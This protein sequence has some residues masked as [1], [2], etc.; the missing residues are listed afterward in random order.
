MTRLRYNRAV[1]ADCVHSYHYCTL[2]Y[3]AAPSLA[4]IKYYN[5]PMLWHSHQSHDRAWLLLFLA[6]R[7]KS[8]NRMHTIYSAV[9]NALPIPA[10]IIDRNGIILDINPAF[11]D[12][13][14]SMGKSIRREDRVGYHICDFAIG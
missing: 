7:W 5:R 1:D 10:T 12:F 3:F 2:H 14:R 11:I 6:L 13:A 4:P 9:Y 8:L